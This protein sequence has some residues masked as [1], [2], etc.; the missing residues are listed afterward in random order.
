[1]AGSYQHVTNDDGTFRG[2]DRFYGM[3]ENLG[4]AYEAIEHMHFMI[5]HLA[6]GDAAKISE[7]SDA[8]YRASQ[9]EPDD[10]R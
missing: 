8:F 3:I 9:G 5:R 1:M 6:G 10:A 7:A 2:D 4:D